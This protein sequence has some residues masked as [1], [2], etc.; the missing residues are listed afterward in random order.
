MAGTTVCS[1]SVNTGETIRHSKEVSRH[2]L[3]PSGGSYQGAGADVAALEEEEG[4][5]VAAGLHGLNQ[6]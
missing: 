6:A 2:D 5:C 4:F 1:E 3:L